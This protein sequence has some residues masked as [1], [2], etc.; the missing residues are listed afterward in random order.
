[1][2]EHQY[3]AMIGVTQARGTLPM[4][5]KDP[6]WEEGNAGLPCNGAL[7]ARTVSPNVREKNLK[8]QVHLQPQKRTTRVAKTGKKCKDATASLRQVHNKVEVYAA[9]DLTRNPAP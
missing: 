5:P 2:A 3:V 8:E 7:R 4:M 9:G 6:A 1:M